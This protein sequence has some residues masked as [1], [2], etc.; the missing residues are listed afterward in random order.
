MRS[1]KRQERG[2]T[3]VEL[4]VVV[5][6]LGILATAVVFNVSGLIGDAKVNKAKTDIRTLKDACMLFKAKKGKWPKNLDELTQGI[7]AMVEAVPKD[8]WDSKYDY[9]IVNNTAVITCSGVGGAKGGDAE[10]ADITSE[11]LGKAQ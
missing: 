10:A 6:I 8:P 9:R 3:M 7:Q 4:M 1:R 2:F 5:I 11:D